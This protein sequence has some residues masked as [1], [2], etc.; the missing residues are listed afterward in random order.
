MAKES[1][2]RLWIG[3]ILVV[4]GAMILLDNLDILEFGDLIGDWWPI[5][6][7]I[8]GA[9]KLKEPNKNTAFVFITIG[10][11]FLLMSL[12]IVDLDDILQFWPLILIFIGLS[13]LFRSRREKAVELSE[14]RFKLSAIFGGVEREIVS[15]DLQD[16]EVTVVFGGAEIDMTKATIAESGATLDLT[17]MFGGIELRVPKDT[18][19]LVLGSPILG[20]IEN[21]TSRES[22]STQPTIRCHCNVVAGGIEI[23]D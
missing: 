16:G 13:L 8:I 2:Q 14:N 18:R 19:V 10:A 3:I 17:A 6:F 12:N 23:R 11:L 9:F 1:S 22:T 15:N 4:I 5:I 21:R 20:G 7:I